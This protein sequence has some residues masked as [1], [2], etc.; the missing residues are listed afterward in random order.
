MNPF[1]SAIA[2]YRGVTPLQRV[3]LGGVRLFPAM[4]SLSGTL[5]AGAEGDAYSAYL[6]RAGGYGNITLLS[7]TGL[8]PGL[9]AAVNNTLGRVEIT[10]TISS[11]AYGASPYAVSVNVEDEVGLHATYLGSIDIEQPAAGVFIL[12]GQSLNTSRGTKVLTSS[13]AQARMFNDAVAVSEFDYFSANNEDGTNFISVT[14]DVTLAEG[15][16]QSPAVGMAAMLADSDYSRG[17][18]CSVAVGARP[19]QAL[20]QAGMRANLYAALRRFCELARAS[21]YSPQPAAYD[22]HGEAN[23]SAGTTEAAY[24]TLESEYFQ[25]FRVAAAQA[26]GDPA[27]VAPLVVSYPAQ[28]NAGG[29]GANNRAINE[30]KRRVAEELAAKDFPTYPFPCATDRT[31]N[32]DA[33]QVLRGEYA[34]LLLRGTFGA[35]PRIVSVTLSGTTFVATFSKSIR[36]RA[37]SNPGWE[38]V[39][40]GLNSAIAEDGFEWVDNGTEI[41]IV[42]GSL[43]YGT[44][45]ITGTLASAPA[46]SLAQQALR[47]ASQTT[48]ASLTSGAAN[49]AGGCVCEDVAGVVSSY[50]PTFTHYP[51]AIPQVFKSVVAP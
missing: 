28:T 27:Y 26:V 1:A 47:Y 45:T 8:P 29:A 46:G 43:V 30:A 9:S 13:W 34:G 14:S 39:G 20:N 33:G 16:G 50:D 12:T 4:L 40:S 11:G 32:T 42:A 23:A 10:G 2:A 17:Y 35:S 6:V 48:T 31:H 36:R 7:A 21:G 22:A 41:A 38:N 49:L 18:F 44:N 15:V 3:V 19:R 5:P 37:T 24:Y 51:W 25:M